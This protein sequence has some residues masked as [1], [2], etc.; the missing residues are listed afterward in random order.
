MKKIILS[1]FLIVVTFWGMTQDVVQVEYS[2]DNDWASGSSTIINIASSPDATVSFTVNL[3]GVAAGYH[4]L[5]IRTRDSDGNWGLT[6]RRLIEVVQ[7][8]APVV[9]AAEYLF[10]VDDGVGS[11]TTIN[12]SAPGAD[13]QQNFLADL[14]TLPVGYHKLYMRS[15]DTYG[16]WS[17]T[18]R[19]SVEVIELPV[20]LV[21]AGEY[22][23][24]SDPGVGKGTFITFNSPSP[25]SSFH[26]KVPLSNI[27]VGAHTFYVRA[28]DSV[29]YNWSHTARLEDTVVTSVATGLWSDINTWSNRKIPDSS[30]VVLLHHNVIVDIIAYCRSLTSF[31]GTLVSVNPGQVLNITG[32]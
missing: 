23:F 24:N 14:A 7:P 17:G 31:Q 28:R 3:A 2:L 15:R 30:T 6:T 1:I 27:P 13:I 21:H 25:D 19:R 10:D 12:V 4:M 20:R 8:A 9:D 26:F 5:Y 11:G 29:N 16:A 32:D 22:F 18:S